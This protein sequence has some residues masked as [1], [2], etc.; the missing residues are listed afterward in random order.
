MG[1]G[2]QNVEFRNRQVEYEV[3]EVGMEG[4]YFSRKLRMGSY[5]MQRLCYCGYFVFFTTEKADQN[6]H[7][8]ESPRE[9]KTNKSHGN[10]PYIKPASETSMNMEFSKVL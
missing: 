9:K 7:V 5:R 8:F 2:I 1:D 6:Q 4:Q 10:P 3:P